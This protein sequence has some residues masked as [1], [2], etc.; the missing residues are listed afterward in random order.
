MFLGFARRNFSSFAKFD[1][2][3]IFDLSVSN[4]KFHYRSDVVKTML[5]CRARIKVEQLIFII[6]ACAGDMGMTTYQD[7]RFEGVNP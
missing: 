1:D 7:M 4:F 5:A 6:L 3:Q 2:D